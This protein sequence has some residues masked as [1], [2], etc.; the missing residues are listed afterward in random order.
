MIEH[1]A[2]RLNRAVQGPTYRV[3]EAGHCAKGEIFTPL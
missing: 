1:A 3:G 2:D